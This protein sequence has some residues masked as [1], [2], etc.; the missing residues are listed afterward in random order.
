[1][2]INSYKKNDIR[3]IVKIYIEMENIINRAAAADPEGN[4]AKWLLDE[5]PE[6]IENYPFLLM[7]KEQRRKIEQQLQKIDIQV[8]YGE[9]EG[10]GN[11]GHA[12]SPYLFNGS[13]RDNTKYVI[14]HSIWCIYEQFL[15]ASIHPTTAEIFLFCGFEV[16]EDELENILEWYKVTAAKYG[17]KSQHDKVT[18]IRPRRKWSEQAKARHSVKMTEINR[19]KGKKQ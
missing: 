12:A 3:R 6:F 2:K 11:Q 5:M 9:A 1:M 4:Y 14:I 7:L 19:N 16:N 8:G 18:R 13:H 10:Q 15:L 17:F